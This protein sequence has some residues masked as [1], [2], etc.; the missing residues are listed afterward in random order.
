MVILI[1]VKMLITFNHSKLQKSQFYLS[2][3]PPKSASL[4]INSRWVRHIPG[5][6]EWDLN[7]TI[8]I[9]K[10]H[11]W[12]TERRKEPTAI[13]PHWNPEHHVPNLHILRKKAVN[14]FQDV[15]MFLIFFDEFFFVES[16]FS[17]FPQDS[18]HIFTSA[19]DFAPSP[20][21]VSIHSSPPRTSLGIPRTPKP[22]VQFLLFFV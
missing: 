15:R 3:Y 20:G 1:L 13:T 18:I 19:D 17:L 11:P 12:I 6:H 2:M 5:C 16:D 14:G 21:P 8:S 10:L 7:S 4:H 22:M 9:K